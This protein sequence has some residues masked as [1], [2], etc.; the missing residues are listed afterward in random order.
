MA[1]EAGSAPC[2]FDDSSL[3]ET[4]RRAQQGDAAAFEAL[5]RLHCRRVY[6]LCLRMVKNT[7]EAEDLTQDAF[8]QIFRQI[9]TF[10]GESS[11][12]T[13]VYRVTSNLVMM[14]FRKKKRMPGSL[15]EIFESEEEKG[16]PHR[17]CGRWDLYLNGLF[18]RNDLEA[19]INQLSECNRTTFLLHYV[20]G[21]QHQEIAKILGCPVATAKSH[22]FRARKKLRERLSGHFKVS[23]R[24]TRNPSLVQ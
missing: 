10:R 19:A 7:S 11:F 16:V 22:A 5:Y 20:Q 14:H 1:K 8:L 2:K 18:D 13:W 15:E 17:E 12:S 21:Y 9:H 6:G 4:I 24:V 3:L 23:T